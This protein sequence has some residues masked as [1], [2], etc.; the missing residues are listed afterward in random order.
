MSNTFKTKAGTVLPLINLKG[1]DYLEVKY[2]IIWFREEHP[3]CAIETEI[4]QHTDGHSVVRATVK[5][6]NGRIWAMGMKREDAKHFA[7]HIEKAETGAIGRAIAL[8][9]YGTQFAQEME[10][11]ERIVDSPVVRNGPRSPVSLPNPPPPRPMPQGLQA[12]CG[13]NQAVQKVDTNG[14]ANLYGHAL[15]DW[16]IP[17]GKNAGQ[18]LGSLTVTR[19]IQ[20]AEFFNKEGDPK[21]WCKDFVVH[22]QELADFERDVGFVQQNAPEE[23]GFADSPPPWVTDNP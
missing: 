21:G 22:S 8:C 6:E 10:E 2:R 3:N 7:D 18:R 19:R 4:M 20:M 5:D 11:G 16:I 17:K 14:S 23:S 1:K 9:G 13:A 12:A 15:Y